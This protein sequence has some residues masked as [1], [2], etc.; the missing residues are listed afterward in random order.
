MSEQQHEY[1][2]ALSLSLFFP[3]YRLWAFL[4][5]VSVCVCALFFLTDVIWLFQILLQ[6]PDWALGNRKRFLSIPPKGR[7][8][9]QYHH[10]PLL[11]SG[12]YSSLIT[13]TRAVGMGLLTTTPRPDPPSNEA[14]VGADYFRDV[15][16]H[17]D[18]LAT[19][20][21]SARLT[22]NYDPASGGTGPFDDAQKATQ[23]HHAFL[24]FIQELDSY[25]GYIVLS[26]ASTKIENNP[27]EL[28][29]LVELVVSEIG[30]RSDEMKSK[31]SATIRSAVDFVIGP[32][33]NFTSSLDVSLQMVALPAVSEDEEE[34]S[35]SNANPSA[36]VWHCVAT[37]SPEAPV[38][39][40][41]T[42]GPIRSG[43]TVQS[44]SSTSAS[45][46]LV[47][48]AIVAYAPFLAGTVIKTAEE[49]EQTLNSRPA[50]TD[51]LCI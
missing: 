45:F 23:L 12:N 2:C 36:R 24:N 3:S 34:S 44:F 50:L 40:A 19:I 20:L 6:V 41:P 25:S 11:F 38:E 14:P 18:V 4:N 21:D 35:S 7:T 15:R 43:V 9:A 28:D 1:Y 8:A 46:R 39:P 32:R 10:H 17:P 27:S 13:L 26:N 29:L 47:S 31:V 37:L 33:E 22:A 16:N 49:L 30:D 5:C 51:P 48:S 42:T